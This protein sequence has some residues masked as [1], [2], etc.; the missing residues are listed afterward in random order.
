MRFIISAERCYATK[1]CFLL[2]R[3]VIPRE[4]AVDVLNFSRFFCHG[5]VMELGPL[6]QRLNFSV[7]S[8]L[9]A[10]WLVEASV[11]L[12]SAWRC[13]Y[14]AAFLC[15]FPSYISDFFLIIVSSFVHTYCSVLC[16]CANVKALLQYI[17]G[18]FFFQNLRHFK[19]KGNTPAV[20]PC[21]CCLLQAA[22][23][24]QLTK[25]NTN[26]SRLRFSEKTTLFF[27]GLPGC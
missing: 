9:F 18:F 24:H 16:D 14:T 3:Q 21:R 26:T 12:I 19:V 7:R 22:M 27:F 8:P 25:I 10:I 23:K 17:Y 2:S 11:F 13:R 5:T 15:C 6:L 1:T 20:F 4:V